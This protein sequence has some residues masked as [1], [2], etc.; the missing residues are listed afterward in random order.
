MHSSA[1]ERRD[2]RGQFLRTAPSAAIASDRAVEGEGRTPRA[3]TLR[4]LHEAFMWEKSASVLQSTSTFVAAD[5]RSIFS[6][7]RRLLDIWSKRTIVWR[8]L[9]VYL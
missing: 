8:F 3:F 7:T 6:S 4:C 5:Q 1:L 9:E 2:G